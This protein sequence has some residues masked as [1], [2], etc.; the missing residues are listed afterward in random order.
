MNGDDYK[1]KEM[2]RYARKWK[3][4]DANVRKLEQK[5]GVGETKKMLADGG[6]VDQ[7]LQHGDYI[8]QSPK[9]QREYRRNFN[10]RARNRG[11]TAEQARATTDRT[12]EKLDKFAK[13]RK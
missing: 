1:Q 2:Q 5:Y 11:M 12:F 7:C 13:Y 8:S 4:S 9:E 10:E 6:E 3:M